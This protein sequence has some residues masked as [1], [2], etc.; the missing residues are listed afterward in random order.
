LSQQYHD[1]S[2]ARFIQPFGL[3][4]HPDLKELW[5]S[6]LAATRQL[7][8]KLSEPL[9]APAHK[10][11]ELARKIRSMAR[12]ILPNATATTIVVTANARSIRHFLKW[13][14]AI[15]GDAEMR[16]V[17][18]LFFGL[19]KIEAPSVVSDFSIKEMDDGLPLIY[20]I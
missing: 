7:Y 11:K 3:D 13:R 17:S 5:Q 16:F 2:Q 12:S 4:D 18:S 9:N 20:Q 1:E 6:S 19:L 10:N 15:L 14:G 8:A